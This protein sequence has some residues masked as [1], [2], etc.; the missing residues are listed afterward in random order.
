[1]FYFAS[2]MQCL[3]Q[4]AFG[5]IWQTSETVDDISVV[6]YQDL[7]FEF[8]FGA[9]ATELGRPIHGA[10]DNRTHVKANKFGMCCV[11]HYLLVVCEYVRLPKKYRHKVGKPK[12]GIVLEKKKPKEN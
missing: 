6:P 12:P 3:S 4:L 8:S 11:K 2:A 10:D 5:D 9:S 7:T 1:M